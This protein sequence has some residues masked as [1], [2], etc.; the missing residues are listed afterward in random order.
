MRHC[1]TGA[2]FSTEEGKK[3]GDDFLPSSLLLLRTD[4]QRAR[5][6]D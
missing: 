1:V 2:R 5:L 4:W 6:E 3:E